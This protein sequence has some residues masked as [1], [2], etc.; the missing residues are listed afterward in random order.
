MILKAFVQRCF[1]FYRIMVLRFVRMA[2]LFVSLFGLL[3]CPLRYFFISTCTVE[4]F[5]PAGDPRQ[6]MDYGRGESGPPAYIVPDVIK[7]FVQFF[8]RTMRELMEQKVNEIQ[9][10]KATAEVI[11]QKRYDIQ[12]LYENK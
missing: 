7:E 5:T 12:N 9:D 8:H 11:E 2:L 3:P 4:I 1:T 10:G 6:D